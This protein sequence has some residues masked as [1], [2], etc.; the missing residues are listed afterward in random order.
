MVDV[1][2]LV[3]QSDSPNGAEEDWP[4]RASATIVEYVGTVR[5]KT[6]GPA[7]AASRNVVYFVAIGLI[8]LIVLIVL[9]VLLVRV[10]VSVTAYAPFVE[11][12]ETWLA[13]MILG[14]LFI[15]GGMLLWWK[16]EAR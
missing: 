2:P 4:A 11:A 12:G 9:L 8:A 1:D 6:T 16:K 5:D 10:L 15:I 13:Y 14:G 7:L 3:P